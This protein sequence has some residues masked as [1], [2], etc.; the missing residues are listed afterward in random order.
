VRSAEQ[1]RLRDVILVF[2]PVDRYARDRRLSGPNP[3]PLGR[4]SYRL[5]GRV[6]GGTR[7]DLDQPYDHP[8]ELTVV[9]SPAGYDT[10]FGTVTLPDGR[11]FLADLPDGQYVVQASS[12]FYQRSERDD[13]VVPANA[14]PP[15]PPVAAYRFD[16]EPSYAYP[17]P[18]TS[19]LA[20][21]RG[22]T[23]LRGAV[24]DASGDGTEGVIVQVPNHSNTYQTDRSGRWVLAFADSEPAGAVTVRF[25]LP[26]G[27]VR[28]VAG[29]TLR[30]GMS[31][32]FAQTA[33]AGRVLA[34]GAAAPAAIIEVAGLPG[35]ATTDAGGRWL[36]YLQADQPAGEVDVRASLA[37]GRSSV[38]ADVPVQPFRTNPVPLFQFP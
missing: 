8:V 31:N 24:H 11:R 23:L 13:I 35:T 18:L 20:Q 6:V 34:G 7:R 32:A 21:G 2:D 25:D 33:L 28:N 19:T 17:F 38:Q 37:D 4:I 3:R 1:L 14:P 29:V 10:F 22:P 26:D 30:P 5:V 12:P 16:L 9:T 36:Y 27:T 15:G